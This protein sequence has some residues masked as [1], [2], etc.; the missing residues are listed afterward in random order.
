MLIDEQEGGKKKMQNLPYLI[1]DHLLATVVLFQHGEQLD[2]VRIL[3]NDKDC[4]VLEL[5]ATYIRI[6]SD[7]GP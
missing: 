3:L 2:D 6:K 7:Y 4:T 1:V 5:L